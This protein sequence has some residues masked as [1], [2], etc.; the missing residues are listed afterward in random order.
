MRRGVTDGPTRTERSEPRYPAAGTRRGAAT[1]GSRALRCVPR[2]GEAALFDAMV[3]FP[4]GR[5]V[6]GKG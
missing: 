3:K 1:S 5:I 6:A 4:S 2:F